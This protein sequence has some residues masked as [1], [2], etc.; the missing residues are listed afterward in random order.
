MGVNLKRQ[1]RS[2]KVR[3]EQVRREWADALAEGDEVFGRR[4]DIPVED[5]WFGFPEAIPFILKA[6]RGEVPREWGPHLLFDEDGALVGNGGWKG[7]PI[8]G[9]AEIGYAVAPGRQGRGIAT[10]AVRTF[11]EQARRAALT[12]VVAHTLPNESASTTVLRRCG[13]V[14]VGDAVDPD[15][16]PVWRWEL[17]VDGSP[18]RY[19][20]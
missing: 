2:P 17:R 15:E 4:F 11:I 5:G 9:T 20:G 10:A 12:T 6:G 18:E 19:A 16:G 1:L 7:A 8:D 13:F 14:R 3:V